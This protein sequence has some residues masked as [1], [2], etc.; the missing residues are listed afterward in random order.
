MSDEPKRIRVVIAEDYVPMQEN[1]R[2]ALP[3]ECDV[4]GVVE[5]GIAA[6]DVVAAQQPDLLLLDVS[7]PGMSGFAVAER[8]S[9]C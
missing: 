5:D 7:M 6:L 8:L 9:G 2:R 3:L 4:I 1:I